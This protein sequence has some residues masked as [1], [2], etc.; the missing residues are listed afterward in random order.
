MSSSTLNPTGQPGPMQPGDY[1]PAAQSQVVSWTM[2]RLAPP[3]PLY[4]TVDD[5]LAA[6]CTSSQAGEVVT[7]A[8]R[9]LRASDGKIVYGSQ[10]SFPLTAYKTEFTPLPLT[11]GFLLSIGCSA[12]RATTRGQTWVRLILNPAATGFVTPALVLMADYVTGLMTPGYPNGRVLS[13]LEGPGYVTGVNTGPP[14]VG[15][16][17]SVQV[18]SN[19]R[20]HILTWEVIVTTAAGGPNRILSLAFPNSN[21]TAT[22]CYA[23]VSQAPSTT[24][25]YVGA[26]IAPYVIPDPS[27][28]FVPLPNIGTA[29]GG[30]FV[31]SDTENL[32]A[33]DQIGGMLLGYEEWIDN[34]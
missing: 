14:P 30:S 10:S 26:P 12:A 17:V 32:A 23:T 11:E 8:Y 31:Q 2:K 4:V 19:A 21:V 18:P 27:L 16:E 33:G 20:W 22:F 9:M 3:S 25:R 28:V 13:S 5:Q 1:T 6:A 24:V 29:V 15:E 7:I 34:A